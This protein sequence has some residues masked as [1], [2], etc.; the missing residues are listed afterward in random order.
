LPAVIDAYFIYGEGL[1]AAA[2]AQAEALRNAGLRVVLH[3]N[4]DGTDASF[5]SQM[6][7]A[8]ASGARFAI[9]RGTDEAAADVFAV[10]NLQDG[11][12]QSLSF[13]ALVSHV[14]AA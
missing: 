14:S 9:I 13:D 10:K 12:Q 7:K 5:K 4:A 2:F 11:T 8:D 1:S 3:A 6:K